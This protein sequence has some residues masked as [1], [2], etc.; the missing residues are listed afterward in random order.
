MATIGNMPSP[1]VRL[2]SQPE[3]LMGL[4]DLD[5]VLDR[6]PSQIDALHNEGQNPA[7]NGSQ[8]HRAFTTGTENNAGVPPPQ[9]EVKPNNKGVPW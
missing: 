2:E 1:M 5:D 3:N 4:T 8:S 9:S 7:S 6:L